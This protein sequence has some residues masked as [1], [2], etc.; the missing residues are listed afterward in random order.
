LQAVDHRRDRTVFILD[1]GNGRI[2]TARLIVALNRRDQNCDSRM[3]QYLLS[4]RSQHQ[5]PD[6]TLSMGWH[7]YQIT[8]PFLGCFDDGFIRAI[9]SLAERIMGYTGLARCDFG[10]RQDGARGARGFFREVLG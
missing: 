7:E 3:H 6:A 1:D 8:T 5:T 10:L 4:L 2:K 9:A